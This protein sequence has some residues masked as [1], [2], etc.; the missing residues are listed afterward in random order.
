MKAMGEYA[1][2]TGVRVDI[3]GILGLEI[4]EMK[5][6]HFTGKSCS[7]NRILSRQSKSF[8]SCSHMNCCLQKYTTHRFTYFIYYSHQDKFKNSRIIKIHQAHQ[9]IHKKQ[10]LLFCITCFVF[11]IHLNLKRLGFS[12]EPVA[13]YTHESCA[14][15]NHMRM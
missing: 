5:L 9:K 6:N 4:G 14:N 11:V 2:W 3:S 15:V 13:Q 7:H 12:G 10:F 1:T 8:V